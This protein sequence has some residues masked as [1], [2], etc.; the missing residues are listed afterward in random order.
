LMG[1]CFLRP[2]YDKLPNARVMVGRIL[3]LSIV[4]GRVLWICVSRGVMWRV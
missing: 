3:W 1:A 2:E 4:L